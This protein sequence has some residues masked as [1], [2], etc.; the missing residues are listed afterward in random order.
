MRHVEYLIGAYTV[1]PGAAETHV[2]IGTEGFED[3]S[4]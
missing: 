1:A 2:N 4:M 3:H